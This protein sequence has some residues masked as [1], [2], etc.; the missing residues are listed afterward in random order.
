VNPNSKIPALMDYGEQTPLRVFESGA[1]LLYL[2][3]KFGAFLP[4]DR[5]G[6]D[7]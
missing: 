7:R 4:K 6:S 3:D 2:A 5:D 1:I